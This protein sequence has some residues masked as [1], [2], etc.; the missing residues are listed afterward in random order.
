MLR[1]LPDA[2]RPLLAA[3]EP[4][5][6][7]ADDGHATP[8]RRI[9]V[10]PVSDAG[11]RAVART[12]D[13]PREHGVHVFC[14]GLRAWMSAATGREEQLPGEDESRRRVEADADIEEHLVQVDDGRP[15][16]ASLPATE[17]APA[18]LVVIDTVN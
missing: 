11:R 17:E 5:A 8:S 14:C 16:P 18:R 9:A 4:A 12:E 3:H 2:P 1:L 6:S 15:V 13:A 10:V 7:A